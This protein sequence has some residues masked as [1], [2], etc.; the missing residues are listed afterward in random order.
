MMTM[1]PEQMFAGGRPRY[2]AIADA[3]ATEIESGRMAPESRLPPQRD[4]AYRL[5][6]TVGT[7]TRAYGVLARRRL[8]G[9]HVGRGTYV[10]PRSRARILPADGY[11]D[12][13]R[14]APP[15]P[16][17]A[18]LARECFLAL[19]DDTDPA[20]HFDYASA[21]GGLAPRAA[22]AT[23]SAQ[24]GLDA[25]AEQLTIFG[26]A[27]QA[28]AAAFMAF[29][30]DGAL[31]EA[32]TY[33][34]LLN[35]AQATRLPLTGVALDEEGAR[36]DAIERAAR[37]SGARLLV[38]V[39]TL[40]NPH[41]TLMGEARRREIAALARR[42]DLILVEDDVYGFAPE[43]RPPPLA[44]FAPERT[45][46]ITG[47]SKCLAPGLRVAWTVAPERFRRGL[48]AALYAMS[49]CCPPLTAEIVR[50]W[51]ESGVA[52]ELLAA[53]R[54][55][56]VLR[57]ALAGELLAGLRVE[58]HPA[59][60]HAFLHLPEAWT[61]ETFAAAARE[62]GIGVVPASAFAADASAMPRAVRIS[63][64]QA[65]DR[66]TLRRALAALGALAADAPHRAHGVI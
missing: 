43:D 40:Q 29:G 27:Q 60:F 8:V 36:P 11:I 35:I 54:R 28:L 64:S 53:Q 65:P 61:P 7:V 1:Q 22:M 2:L 59:S 6:V 3:I 30:A 23:W 19:A 21:A 25:R 41:N 34:G 55:E 18:R 10:K 5:G 20:R 9:G 49:V 56:T 42:L 47:A 48:E 33:P 57:Q 46:Y 24:L 50:G 32:M 37:H 44:S 17:P 13:T 16:P 38:L 39:P 4:L 31:V 12:L 52:A 62:R 45:I 58:R 26:G 51:I 14:N 63:L 66:E 15:V